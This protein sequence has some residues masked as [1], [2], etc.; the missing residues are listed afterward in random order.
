MS[1][2]YQ[3][4]AEKLLREFKGGDYAFGLNAL[5]RLRDY[6]KALGSRAAIISGSTARRTGLLDRIV[7]ELR[8]A[9][10]EVV[11]VIRGARP[12]TPKE[13]VYRM[14]YQLL[15]LSWDFVIA[16]GGGSCLDGAKA[17]LVLALYG[18]LIEDYFGVGKISQISRDRR[19]PL[20][21]IQMASGSASH[22]TKYSNITDLASLQKKL[23]VDEAII[24]PKAIFQY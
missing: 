5:D 4:K 23:I 15:R 19:I 24:P 21:A 20:L 2:D 13:D 9:G 7:R 12:N 11:G 1:E 22:L 16:I 17:A 10:I 14:A 8:E 3:V 6:S 18:G